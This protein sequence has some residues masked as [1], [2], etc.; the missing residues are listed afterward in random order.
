MKDNQSSKMYIVNKGT[1]EN[2]KHALVECKRKRGK[3]YPVQK[4]ICYLGK[5]PDLDSAIRFYELLAQDA[6]SE[7]RNRGRLIP[8]K[9]KISL[10]DS[11]KKH[12]ALWQINYRL[13]KLRRLKKAREEKQKAKEFGEITKQI[14]PAKR[15]ASKSLKLK[16]KIADV[17]KMICKIKA[18][19]EPAKWDVDV[20]RGIKKLIKE[21]QSFSNEL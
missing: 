20:K 8:Q 1:L 3:K 2:P 9:P 11:F 10:L 21:I 17:N 19:G 15:R 6:R 16:F 5:C 14:T 4:V 18:D 13:S 7:W 12:P